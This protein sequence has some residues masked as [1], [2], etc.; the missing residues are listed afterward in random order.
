M[1]NTFLATEGRL[2]EEAEML[3][4]AFISV[5]GMNGGTFGSG[6]KMRSN[7]GV[8]RASGRI[9][10]LVLRVSFTLVK[11]LYRVWKSF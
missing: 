8:G 10:A 4:G 1:A 5:L 9:R 6:S 11:S 7:F 2:V 3:R